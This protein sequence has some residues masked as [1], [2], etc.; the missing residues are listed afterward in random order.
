MNYPKLEKLNLDSC[1]LQYIGERSFDCTPFLADLYLVHLPLKQLPSSFGLAQFSLKWIKFWALLDTPVYELLNNSYLQN[2]SKLDYLGLGGNKLQDLNTNMFP[3]Q[4]V[5]LNLMS[6]QLEAFPNLSN[7]VPLLQHG[8]FMVNRITTIPEDRIVGLGRMVTFYIN[9]N[10]LERISSLASMLQLSELNVAY[11]N[12]AS[13][14]D[15][16]HL[17]LLKLFLA[18]NPLVCNKTLCWVRMWPWMK[19]PF[20]LDDPKCV[21]P[22][23]LAGLKL[24]EVY[25]TLMHCYEG[26]TSK[27]NLEMYIMGFFYALKTL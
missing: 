16:Y 27:K 19:K 2:F 21:E 20:R 22:T 8:R 7:S 11:N 24:M 13:L 18:G 6:T 26:K 1:G 12:L 14:P 3:S 15:L 17:P 5:Y 4:L 10:R 25:P 23:E 9:N